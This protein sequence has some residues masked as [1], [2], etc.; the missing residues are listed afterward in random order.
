M[1]GAGELSGTKTDMAINVYTPGCHLLCHDDVIGSRRVS[2]ILYLLDPDKEWKAEYGGALRLYPTKSVTSREGGK[3]MKLPSS[4][5]SKSIPPQFNQL[6]FFEVQPGESFH[7]VGEVY[8]KVPGTDGLEN[9]D[10]IRMAIS[11]WYHI[12]QEG[13]DGYEEG[14]E[15]RL[16]E[17]SSLQQLQGKSD[18]VDLPQPAWQE[19]TNNSSKA[20]STQAD[21]NEEDLEFLLK[22]ITPS[23]LTPDTAEELSGIFGDESSLRLANFLNKRFAPALHKLLSGAEQ[24]AASS[25]LSSSR[26]HTARPPHKHR[27]LYRQ[28]RFNDPSQSNNE[29]DE[30][31]EVLFP[32]LAFKKWLAL[33][34]DLNLPGWSSKS[35]VLGRRFRRGLDYTLAT[36]YDKPLPQLEV[37]LG[38]TPT[39]GWG[40]DDDREDADGENEDDDDDDENGGS[41]SI[42]KIAKAV[43]SNGAVS[44]SVKEAVH[45][46]EEDDSPGGY[47][48]Y[49]VGDDDEDHVNLPAGSS[50]T[51]A[52]ERRK[53]DPAI[54]KSAG[55]GDEDDGVLFSQP[56]SWNT[57]TVVLRDTGVLRFVKY[58]SRKAK[59]DRWDITAEWD[60]S[61]MPDDEV[62]DGEEDGNDDLRDDE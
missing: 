50:H 60:L 47:E 53:A 15:E 24:D 10:R 38:L 19:G 23:Y 54:Y 29:Y 18:D 28:A 36:G 26:W 31:L 30:L 7:D 58:V 3:E 5:W 9:A 6:A 25:A 32:S 39:P 59:G 2:Y 14:L 34:T 22:Y 46:D 21:L 11:G 41:S 61:G 33:I 12:P 56:A 37:C 57:M 8:H 52:G 17:K 62:Q 35:N 49:M 4:E 40:A 43:A 16:A 20:K 48:M 55:A 27:F 44:I 51:G 45:D 42:A 1:T 13:E